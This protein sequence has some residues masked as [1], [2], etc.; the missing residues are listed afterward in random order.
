MYNLFFNRYKEKVIQLREEL[1]DSES[2]AQDLYRD[3]SQ[4][5]QSKE[6]EIASLKQSI[7]TVFFIIVYYHLAYK[8]E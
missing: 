2:N 3:F 7:D 8:R 6:Q 4:L 1:R 5:V